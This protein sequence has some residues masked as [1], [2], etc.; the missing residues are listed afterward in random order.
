MLILT[1]FTLVYLQV[2]LGQMLKLTKHTSTTFSALA[3]LKGTTSKLN[4]DKT[5]DKLPL[6][7][8]D[9]D[10]V[11]YTV[12]IEV[13]GLSLSVVVSRFALSTAPPPP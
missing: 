13:G 11:T 7:T 9:A 12:D 2:T 3:R 8:R 10:G 4:L 5:D 6:D 1:T